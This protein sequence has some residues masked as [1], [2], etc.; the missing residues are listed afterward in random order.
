MDTEQHNWLTE[1]AKVAAENAYFYNTMA[2][3]LLEKLVD[4]Q[5]SE[6]H[7]K[8]YGCLINTYRREA[9]EY[10]KSARLCRIDLLGG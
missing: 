3:H 2:M 1:R 8:Y 5:T 7:R 10:Y 4:P 9:R 6:R